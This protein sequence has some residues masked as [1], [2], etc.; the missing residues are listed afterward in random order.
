[1]SEDV[2][3]P[4]TLALGDASRTRDRVRD[5]AAPAP[6]DLLQSRTLASTIVRLA[7]TS[8]HSAY[9]HLP[10]AMLA[11]ELV[12][13]RRLVHL[14]VESA[15]LYCALCQAVVEVGADSAVYGI[16][17]RTDDD[18]FNRL[19]DYQDRHYG[20]FARLVPE[21]VFGATDLFA[22]ASIDLLVA[23]SAIGSFGDV[24]PLWV[25]KLSERG[26]LVLL[27]LHD[28]REPTLD[29]V[30]PYPVL[31]LTHGGGALIA[32]VG[33]RQPESALEVVQAPADTLRSLRRQLALRGD[34]VAATAALIERDA[35]IRALEEEL[36]RLRPTVAGALEELTQLRQHLARANGERGT[37]TAGPI[38]SEKSVSEHVDLLRTQQLETEGA[39]AELSAV[40][41]LL[42][43]GLT[44][45][46]RR[47][48]RIFAAAEGTTVF[49]RAG[50]RLGR[51]GQQL[52]AAR[53]HAPEPLRS[54]LRALLPRMVQRRR[55]RLL[56]A[57]PVIRPPIP[58]RRPL[59][60]LSTTVSVI[61][62]TLDA[63]PGFGRVLG[64]IRGQRGLG[65]IEIL[66]VDSGSTDGTV[67]LAR[68]YGATVRQ[69]PN[70]EFNHGATRDAAA[71]RASGDVLLM[72]V[73][74]AVLVG[75][76]ALRM[77]VLELEDDPT[78][79]GTSPRQVPRADTDLY[80][81]YAVWAH[82]TARESWR[83]ARQR[84]PWQAMSPTE[85]RA[86]AQLDNVCAAIRRDAWSALRFRE[87]AFA[88]DLDFGLRAVERGW[89]IG[90]CQHAAVIHSHT[91]SAA[92]HV[93]RLAV[94]R[95]Y[96][97]KLLSLPLNET[98]AVG[99]E[100]VVAAAHELVR[101]LQAAF[102]FA[103]VPYEEV[104]L[105]KHLARVAAG[106]RLELP[107]V[108]PEGSLAEIAEL[109]GWTGD[110]DR[111]TLAKLRSQLIDQLETGMPVRYAEAYRGVPLAEAND[112]IAKVAAAEIGVSAG[113][114]LRA[115]PTE[116]ELAD[117]LQASI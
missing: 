91:R 39:R 26:V 63:G 50:A 71:E 104:D 103:Q 20:D 84:K 92:Y 16:G 55:A 90:A 95:L 83:A 67:E 70:A 115:H 57:T 31:E 18:A 114:A 22:D 44:R 32:L 60:D 33:D 12:R 105:G 117:R 56:Y 49:T 38:V 101:R 42:S 77:L 102:A 43:H 53:S 5:W 76:D 80:G 94:D 72:T 61:I 108:D 45:P 82:E 47:A 27:D 7:G 79:I 81:A 62:P 73:Q 64:A 68:R 17:Q 93:R 86:A 35:R 96:A 59:R 37:S 109:C 66:V 100:S 97:A 110:A 85:R 9:E 30:R 116:S 4:S 11:V 36:E 69:I 8:T 87:V 13:P 6:F 74:D 34:H 52:T 19:S 89:S 15:D 25:P 98:A 78:T 51:P 29:L 111:A 40:R 2:A 1:M 14:G 112:F 58:R 107:A 65:D 10:L 41:R 28:Q 88:E 99:L 106:L 54:A 3:R 21:D 113:D 46:L 48:K 24:I 75:R 23:A